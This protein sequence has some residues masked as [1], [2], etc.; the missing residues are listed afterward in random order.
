M[1]DV[2]AALFIKK[3]KIMNDLMEEK[4]LEWVYKRMGCFPV[5]LLC[6]ALS[7]VGC[8]TIHE[9]EI[10][11]IHDTLT[12]HHSDT[13]REYKSKT[14]YDTIN[15]YTEKIITLSTNGDT[16]KEIHNYFE[17]ERIIEKDS[18]DVYKALLDSIKQSLNQNHE[19]E[20]VIEK[21]PSFWQ[22]WKWKLVAAASIILTLLVL[23]KT[24]VPKIKDYLHS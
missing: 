7:F 21:K 16:I 3:G 18:S 10:V 15:I 1:R 8:K 12:V 4:Y 23:L 19:K 17:R 14:L 24:F 22:Q 13:V 5:L 11:E 2:W 6:I 20:K 9:S